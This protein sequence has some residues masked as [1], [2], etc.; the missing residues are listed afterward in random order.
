MRASGEII[1]RKMSKPLKSS[2]IRK[3][4]SMLSGVFTIIVNINEIKRN[5]TVKATTI[6]FTLFISFLINL[7]I[8]NRKSNGR[9]Q[10]NPNIM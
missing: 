6:F 5:I 10:S 2:G 3:R 9:E 4:V 1:P 7:Y 8:P